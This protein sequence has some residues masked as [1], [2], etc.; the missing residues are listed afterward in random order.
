MSPLRP[1]AD[2]GTE[3]EGSR[4]PGRGYSKG[5][6]SGGPRLSPAAPSEVAPGTKP[7]RPANTHASSDSGAAP[8]PW[9]TPRLTAPEAPSG[10][11][12]EPSENLVVPSSSPVAPQPEADAPWSQAR[13]TGGREGSRPPCSRPPS[14]SPRSPESQKRRS[15]NALSQPDLGSPFRPG[16][17]PASCSP[18]LYP[19]GGRAARQPCGRAARD[20]DGPP[21]SPLGSPRLVRKRNR[22]RKE[23][24]S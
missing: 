15:G 13:T 21:S 11:P 20:L 23:N 4:P 5:A 16:P 9:T 3:L 18:L 19:R 12:P 22:N 14:L 8:Q 7:K 1:M 2:V 6:A 17:G 24:Q 10:R